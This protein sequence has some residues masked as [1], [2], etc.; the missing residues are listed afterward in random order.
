MD[1]APAT[2]P[3][4]APNRPEISPRWRQWADAD[5][6]G[7][8]TK[9]ATTR[10]LSNALVGFISVHLSQTEAPPHPLNHIQKRNATVAYLNLR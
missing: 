2:T 8:A 6:S 5:D 9:A 10:P 7:M 1:A 3:V 4:T